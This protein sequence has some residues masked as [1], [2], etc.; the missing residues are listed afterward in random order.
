MFTTELFKDIIIFAFSEI[1]AMGARGY[2]EGI[3]ETGDVIEFD[4]IAEPDAW[5][6]LKNLFPILKDCYFNG[7]V[8]CRDP[9]EPKEIVFSFGVS[10]EEQKGTRVARGWAHIYMGFGN[11]LV[12]RK[13]HI[14][15]FKQHLCDLT[16]EVGL[17]QEWRDRAKLYVKSL[18]AMHKGGF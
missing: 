1:G 17:Y 4:Y 14:Q 13:D 18:K 5:E 12:V 15:G 9:K 7:S 3:S 6:K 16:T 8:G 10:S 11:H 2:F